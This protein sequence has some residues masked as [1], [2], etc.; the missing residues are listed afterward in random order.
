MTYAIRQGDP[1]SS[2][3]AFYQAGTALPGSQDWV[4]SIVDADLTYAVSVRY[5]AVKIGLFNEK[6]V[7]VS[8]CADETKA[9]NKTRKV[10]R[11]PPTDDSY[12]LY[13][14]RLELNNKGVWQTMNRSG[15]DRDSII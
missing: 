11:V 13:S 6:S 8:Y 5:Y 10:D 7:G 1:N 15:F 9:F 14:T 12:V 4:K 2:A 3:L